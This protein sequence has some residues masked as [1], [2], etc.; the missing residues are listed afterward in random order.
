MEQ[1]PEPVKRKLMAMIR[2]HP[3]APMQPLRR[4]PWPGRNDPCIA[5]GCSDAGKRV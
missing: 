1:A 2:R 4:E 3:A 5:G